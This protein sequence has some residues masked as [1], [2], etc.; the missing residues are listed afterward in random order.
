MNRSSRILWASIVVAVSF[1]SVPAEV[2]TRIAVMEM[3]VS[4]PQSASFAKKVVAEIRTALAQV[5]A[6][7][8]VSDKELK[9]QSKSMG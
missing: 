5:S 4:S 6:V 2:P 9:Q 7:E 3:Q 1:S 8:V